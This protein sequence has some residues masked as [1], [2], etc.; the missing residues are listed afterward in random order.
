M[1]ITIIID[2]DSGRERAA[3]ARAPQQLRWDNL[4]HRY[5]NPEENV[6]KHEKTFFRIRNKALNYCQ[7]IYNEKK[8]LNYLYL[9]V[10]RLQHETYAFIPRPVIQYNI[11]M[12]HDAIPDCPHLAPL[13]VPM[14]GNL[15]R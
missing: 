6:L 10:V 9:H 1:F 13:P 15:S 8:D 3:G 7:K 12:V 2:R 5:R 4:S 11:G 14:L